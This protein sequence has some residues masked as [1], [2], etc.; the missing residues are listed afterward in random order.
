MAF[1]RAS[2]LALRAECCATD[3]APPSCELLS[4]E[5]WDEA[6]LRRYFT[7]GGVERPAPHERRPTSPS[8]EVVLF[9][10]SHTGICL[11][12][13]PRTYTLT[14]CSY[15]GCSAMGLHHRTSVSRYRDVVDADVAAVVRRA[16]S[17]GGRR[18][19]SGGGAQPVLALKFGQV[20]VEFVYYLKAVDNPSLTFRV[21]LATQ[22]PSSRR[23]DA[24]Y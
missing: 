12:V 9:G 19:R 4:A 6:A 15:P 14:A 10:D 1:T 2:V 22:R 16:V 21:E 8:Q 23:E 3:V 17:A 11:A 13:E 18:E 5:G 7:S 24:G 20:D